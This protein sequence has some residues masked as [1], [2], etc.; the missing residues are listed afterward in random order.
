V[1][2]EDIKVGL[3]VKHN[4]SGDILTVEQIGGATKCNGWFKSNE[5]R[6]VRVSEVEP[7]ST[8]PEIQQAWIVDKTIFKTRE[9]AVEHSI[10]IQVFEKLI[11]VFGGGFLTETQS[12]IVDTLVEKLLMERQE[13]AEILK[14]E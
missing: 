2:N 13:F 10:R 9:A 5:Q 6:W 1:K 12:A 11:P 8:K 3:K 4:W 7:V 14:G